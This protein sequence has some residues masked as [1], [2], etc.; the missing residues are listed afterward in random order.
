MPLFII[1]ELHVFMTHFYDLMM[2]LVKKRSLPLSPVLCG[3]EA[4]RYIKFEVIR[5]AWSYL[6]VGMATVA[7]SLD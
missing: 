2:L 1:S 7:N 3:N 4:S 6:N 5:G